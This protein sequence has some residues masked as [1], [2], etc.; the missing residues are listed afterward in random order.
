MIYLVVFYL[1]PSYVAL[2]GA[3]IYDP[4]GNE[5]GFKRS[6]LSSAV[7]FSLVPVINIVVASMCTFYYLRDTFSVTAL[8][9]RLK[10]FIKEVLEEKDE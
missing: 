5:V 9:K 3:I 1:I 10:K 6:N 7:A 2:L 8:K 4:N